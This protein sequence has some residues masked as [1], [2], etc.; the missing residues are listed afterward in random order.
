MITKKDRLTLRSLAQKLPDLVQIGK[1]GISDNVI[2]QIE[3]NLHAH[4]L[5]KIK[6]QS[7]CE[8]PLSE[9]A[10]VISDKLQSDIVTIIGRKIVVYK[11]SDKP[12]IQHVLS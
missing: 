3:E 6:V 7:N 4:E 1:D 8:V 12:N 11:L 5:I 9:L 2:K 10:T